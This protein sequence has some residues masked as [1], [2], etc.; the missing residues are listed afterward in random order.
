MNQKLRLSET[1]ASIAYDACKATIQAQQLYRELAADYTIPEI[2]R[3]KFTHA[4]AHCTQAITYIE[5]FITKERLQ[6]FR[7]QIGEA[8]PFHIDRVRELMRSMTPEQQN[9]IEQ[10]CVTVKE[11][12]TIE[13]VIN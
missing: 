2:L 6:V 9:A 10:L 5:S 12:G 13:A 7:E 4:A 3:N 1:N 11:G 8:D